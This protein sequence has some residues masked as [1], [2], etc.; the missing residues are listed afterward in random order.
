MTQHQVKKKLN[1]LLHWTRQLLDNPTP[2]EQYDRHPVIL[3]GC[4]DIECLLLS[5]K[6]RDQMDAIK[7]LHQAIYDAMGEYV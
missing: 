2:G 6:G 3:S 1:S 4:Y 7:K 5:D